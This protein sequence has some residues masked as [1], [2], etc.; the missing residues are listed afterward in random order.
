MQKKP[1]YIYN[2]FSQ[3]PLLLPS[4]ALTPPIYVIFKDKGYS[5]VF[6]LCCGFSKSGFPCW[7]GSFRLTFSVY[8]CFAFFGSFGCDLVASRLG[9]VVRRILNS[10]RRTFSYFLV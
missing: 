6:F 3:C 10:F 8:K 2:K 1:N 9:I 4:P 5:W 7:V